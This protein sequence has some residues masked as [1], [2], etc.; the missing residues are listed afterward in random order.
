MVACSATDATFRRS[1]GRVKSRPGRRA[2]CSGEEGRAR[3][4]VAVL[5]GAGRRDE[6][7]AL[8]LLGLILVRY[9]GEAEHAGEPGDRLVIV[10]DDES[11]MCEGLG[12]LERP[13]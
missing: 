11:D 2:S 9:K 6:Q 7:P 13:S 1:C 5:A 12:Q 3:R 4:R 10:A 8:V